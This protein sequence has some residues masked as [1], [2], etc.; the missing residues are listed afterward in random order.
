MTKR[1]ISF[2]FIKIGNLLSFGVGCETRSLLS[3]LSSEVS[4]SV[5]W[6]SGSVWKDLLTVVVVT[7]KTRSQVNEAGDMFLWNE[8]KREWTA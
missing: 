3:L 2:R 8:K 6:L 1:V 4:E 5:I 7:R